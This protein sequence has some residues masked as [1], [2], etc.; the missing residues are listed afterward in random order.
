MS[1]ADGSAHHLLGRRATFIEVLGGTEVGLTLP[2]AVEFAA[3]GRIR[4]FL[5]ADTAV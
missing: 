3:G 5:V 4:K 2:A 1:L